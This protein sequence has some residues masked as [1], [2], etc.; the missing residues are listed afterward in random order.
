MTALVL[1]ACAVAHPNTGAPFSPNPRRLNTQEQGSTITFELQP[2]NS[3]P[4]AF[5]QPCLA[6]NILHHKRKRRDKCQVWVKQNAQLGQHFDRKNEDISGFET[7]WFL[8]NRVLVTSS[9][10]IP[11]DSTAVWVCIR[12]ERPPKFNPPEEGK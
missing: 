6:R 8:R 2:R 3:W 10:R 5:P 7:S 9:N 11:S 12:T 1:A 4:R